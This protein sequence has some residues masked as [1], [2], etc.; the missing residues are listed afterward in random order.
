MPS[1]FEHKLQALAE[2]C[3]P[4]GERNIDNHLIVQEI[5]SFFGFQRFGDVLARIWVA[6]YDDHWRVMVDFPRSPDDPY[7]GAHYWF[8]ANSITPPAV[9]VS[10]WNRDTEKFIDCDETE[11]SVIRG[12]IEHVIEAAYKQF[13]HRKTKRTGNAR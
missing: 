9:A 5:R 3:G 13:V 10:T 12:R 1:E 2:R 4:E 11:V 6:K 7:F 8:D